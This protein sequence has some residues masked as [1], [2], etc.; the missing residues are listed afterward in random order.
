MKLQYYTSISFILI[1]LLTI[2]IFRLQ[3][4]INGMNDR[5]S[6]AEA[7][8]EAAMNAAITAKAMAVEAKMLCETKVDSSFHQQ[9]QNFSCNPETGRCHNPFWK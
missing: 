2:G 1:V 9:E 6:I 4:E 3:Y 8:S 5:L 7:R